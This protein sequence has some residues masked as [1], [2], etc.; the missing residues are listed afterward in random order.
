M[1]KNGECDKHCNKVQCLFDGFDCSPPKEKCR[2]KQII[3][4]KPFLFLLRYLTGSVP[5]KLQIPI[6][7]L[8]IVMPLLTVI[9]WSLYFS[10][11]D[12]CASRFENAVCDTLCNNEACLK[13]GL[14]CETG[15]PQLVGED[16]LLTVYCCKTYVKEHFFYHHRLSVAAINLICLC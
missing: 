6:V 11:N 10:N 13:D 7:K 16:S 14:D 1:F 8:E 15:K 2:Y 3:S 12:Y 9:I 4:F 5:K